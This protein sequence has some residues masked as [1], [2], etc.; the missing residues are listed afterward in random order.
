VGN[1]ERG[2]EEGQSAKTKKKTF[3]LMVSQSSVTTVVTN[4][5]SDGDFTSTATSTGGD[6]GRKSRIDEAASY[7]CVTTI[8][9]TSMAYLPHTVVLCELRHGVSDAAASFDI[10]QSPRWRLRERMKTRCV[11]LV[12]CLNIGVDPPDV[13]K[14]SPCTGLECWIDPF[15]MFPTRALEAIGQNLGIQ[16]E[17]W[18]P[19]ALYKVE[20]DPT[21]DHLRKLCL[22]CRKNAKSERVLF[23]YNGHGVPKPT[24]NGELWVFN[25]NFTQ[26]IPLP[27]SELDS[28]LQTPSI[29]VFD[30]SAARVIVNAL[31]EL[32]DWGSSGPLKDRIILAACDAHETL[33]QSVEFP[34]DVFT[35]CL[36]TP[37]KMAL[38]WFCRR[39][40]LKETIDESLIDRIPGRQNDR[41]TLLGELNWIFTA[42]TDTIAW[43]VL[44]RVS[45]TPQNFSRDNPD[46]TCWSLAFSEISYMLRG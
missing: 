13:I 4:H 15:S 1:R 45:F 10:L 11:A 19:R 8:T 39:S 41:R 6:D 9:A 43:N 22:S 30:C 44:P 17:T 29:Y 38:K 32:H 7:G 40:L 37:I 31:A 20:L 35:S 3:C 34:A 33:P 26:Y 27:V 24:P 46:R 36:T 21:K 2:R 18:L 28:W 5:R 14:I 23:H 42:V 12:L 25:K 16:Y